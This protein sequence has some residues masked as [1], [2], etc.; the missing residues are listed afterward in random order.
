[1]ASM[2]ERW[3]L[4]D[5]LSLWHIAKAEYASCALSGEGARHYAGRWNLPGL[6]VVYLSGH[7]ALAALEVFV[8]L[9]SFESHI[10][11]VLVRID[12]P[13]GIELARPAPLP[14]DWH[15]PGPMAGDIPRES[16]RIGH[17]WAQQRETLHLRIPTVM[18]RHDYNY[19]LNPQ[20]S[21]FNQLTVYEPE[22]F[23]FD[24]R[25]WKPQ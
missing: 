3:Q 19:L 10:R 13:P 5:S 2:F 12:I 14:A 24:G 23:A 15:L 7:P 21:D 20:H 4:E 6:P 18:I 16:Q 25:M 22:P 8:H 1:M 11:F 17:L 9:R